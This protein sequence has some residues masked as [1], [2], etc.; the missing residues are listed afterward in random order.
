MT[1]SLEVENVRRELV[2]WGEEAPERRGD[3]TIVA[4]SQCDFTLD[5]DVA[6]ERCIAELRSSDEKLAKNPNSKYDWQRT[7][8]QRREGGGGTISFGVAWYDQEYFDTKKNVFL[9]RMHD[10][11]FSKIGVSADA[12]HVSHWAAVA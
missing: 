8:L 5:D 1:I 3:R 2:L 11:I 10:A 6:V 7:W 4:Q 9:G 12:V